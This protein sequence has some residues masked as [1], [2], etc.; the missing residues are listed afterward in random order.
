MQC[1]TVHRSLALSL[2]VPRST[3]AQ[4]THSFIL[5]FSGYG[6]IDK[7]H[8]GISDTS[9]NGKNHFQ[10][11]G[12]SRELSQNGSRFFAFLDRDKIM[13]TKVF[14]SSSSFSFQPQIGYPI[15]YRLY[16]HFSRDR[17]KTKLKNPT[18]H[19]RLQPFENHLRDYK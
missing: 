14:F 19:A 12:E 5:I 16:V 15:S 7:F 3:M 11:I 1:C 17:L 4:K 6:Q 8:V 2:T 10:N 9:L 13:S 18:N